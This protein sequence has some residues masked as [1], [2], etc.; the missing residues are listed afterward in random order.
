MVQDRKIDTSVTNYGEKLK[1]GINSF[2][3][4]QIEKFP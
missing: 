4:G 1:S 2:K 3:R